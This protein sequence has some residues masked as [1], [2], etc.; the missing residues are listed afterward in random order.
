MYSMLIIFNI[1]E[2]SCFRNFWH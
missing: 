2:Q 1:L